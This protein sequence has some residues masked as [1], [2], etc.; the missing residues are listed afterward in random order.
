MIQNI[1]ILFITFLLTG[2]LAKTD[3]KPTHHTA[4]SLFKPHQLIQVAP[5]TDDLYGFQEILFQT[6]RSDSDYEIQKLDPKKA[7]AAPI[8][9]KGLRIQGLVSPAEIKSRRYF[10]DQSTCTDNQCWLQKVLCSEQ[11]I[12]IEISLVIYDM[13]YNKIYYKKE[14]R[15]QSQHLYCA[16]MP[17]SA[18]STY[19]ILQQLNKKAATSFIK[20]TTQKRN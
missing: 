1:F 9:K 16:D 3:Q 8:E 15:E 4:S 19:Q 2:C 10:K 6:L 14:L 20:E 11:N 18:L 5:F 13:Q 7:D 17:G 12:S